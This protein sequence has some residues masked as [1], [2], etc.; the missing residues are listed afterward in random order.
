MEEFIPESSAATNAE[1]ELVSQRRCHRG[2]AYT[3]SKAQKEWT[4]HNLTGPSQDELEPLKDVLDKVD[5][6]EGNGRFRTRSG[7]G[8][9]DN[10][11]W[12]EHAARMDSGLPS[13]GTDHST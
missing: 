12:E 10:S 1:N 2:E 8:G 6:L 4:L 7:L 9:T 13:F 11:G 5:V 3:G